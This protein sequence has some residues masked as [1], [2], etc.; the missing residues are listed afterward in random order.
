MKRTSTPAHVLASLRELISALDS[1]VPQIERPGEV[2][3]ARDARRLRRD[4]VLRVEELE[5]AGWDD[6]PYNQEL[7]EGILTD[8]GGPLPPS[9]CGTPSCRHHQAI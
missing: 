9:Q 3:I 7:A 8:D 4:A 6:A 1:R 5:R 2:L